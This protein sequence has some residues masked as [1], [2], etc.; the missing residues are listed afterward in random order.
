MN[1]A[2]NTHVDRAAAARASAGQQAFGIIRFWGGAINAG[3]MVRPGRQ[4]LRTL[5]AET[6]REEVCANVP[7]KKRGVDTV[8][9]R[10]RG[11]F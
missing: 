1:P 4:A 11:N 6:H 7:R 3:E 9:R 5:F 2:F 8:R 10:K